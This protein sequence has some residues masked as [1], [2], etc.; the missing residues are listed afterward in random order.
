[1]IRALLNFCFGKKTN[2]KNR[3]RCDARK[4]S[5]RNEH[6]GTMLEA[7]L[8]IALIIL[9]IPFA[10]KQSFN[11]TAEINDI[12]LANNTRNL[13]DAMHSFLETYY[14]PIVDRNSDVD[15]I[16]FST[17]S[18]TVYVTISPTDFIN[19]GFLAPTT[20]TNDGFENEYEFRVKRVPIPNTTPPLYRLE[21]LMYADD[22]GENVPTLRRNNILSTIGSSGG[23]VTA[24]NTINGLHGAWQIDPNAEFGMPL[25][26]A[27]NKTQ[28]ISAYIRYQPPL[29]EVAQ[30]SD[31]HQPLYRNATGPVG[32]NIMATDLNMGGNDII[33]INS[34][35]GA[36]LNVSGDMNIT[37][38][39]VL[40]DVDASGGTI[41]SNDIEVS[42]NTHV[43]GTTTADNGITISAGG[44]DIT[45]KVSAGT[46]NIDINNI[47][48]SGS[49][50]TVD[51]KITALGNME[52]HE[53][54]ADIF[55]DKDAKWAHDAADPNAMQAYYRYYYGIADGDAIYA[56]E[57]AFYDQFYQA[58]PSGT[59]LMNDINLASRGGAALSD[60]LPNYIER[61]QYFLTN[62]TK[63]GTG[64][65][66][67][68]PVQ[69][70]D[71]PASINPLP[72]TTYEDRYEA[73]VDCMT[74]PRLTLTTIAEA[75]DQF[76]P[77][78]KCPYNYHRFMAIRP[79]KW[80]G[81]EI[82]M[83]DFGGKKIFQDQE[84]GWL[85]ITAE[86][87]EES[88]VHN[89]ITYT[90]LKGW[91]VLM[92]YIRR[93][94]L[95]DA[96]FSWN[97]YK[98]P[99]RTMEVEVMT[100]CMYGAGPS[101][102]GPGVD[103]SNAAIAIAAPYKSYEESED[104]VFGVTY[105]APVDVI[106]V[107]NPYISFRIDRTSNGTD[108]G[109]QMSVVNAEY[110]TGSGSDTLYF[111]YTVQ[112]G[113]MDVDGL[114]FA[115]TSINLNG[116]LI[117]MGGNNTEVDFSRIAPKMTNALI[118][119]IRIP[120]YT[121]PGGFVVPEFVAMMHEAKKGVNTVITPISSASDD[122]WTSIKW[123]DAKNACT[124]LDAILPGTYYLIADS[125]W[126]SIANQAFN[127]AYNW[128]GGVIGS[129]C[130]FSGNTGDVSVCEYDGLDPDTGTLSTRIGSDAFAER[131]RLE[132]T[133][134]SNIWD[135]GGN[136]GE[137][138]Y[139]D[140]NA[141]SCKQGG[142]ITLS[143]YTGSATN[144]WMG[145]DNAT[146]TNSALLPDGTS[147]TYDSSFHVGRIENSTTANQY[148]LRGGTSSDL[149]NAGAFALQ[150]KTGTYSATSTGFRCAQFNDNL[151]DTG[152]GCTIIEGLEQRANTVTTGY[153]IEQQIAVLENKSYVIVWKSADGDGYGIFGQMYNAENERQGT[154]FR[155]N[156]TTTDVQE[157]PYVAAIKDGGESGFVVTWTSSGQDGDGKGVYA[158]IY[159]AYGNKVG[160]EFPVNTYKTSDQ[161][162]PNVTG[163]TSGEFVITWDSDG[164]D[165][166]YFGVY[167]Q[168]FD[169]SGN[170]LGNEFRVNTQTTSHQRWS[171]ITY[172]TGGGFVVSYTGEDGDSTGIIAQQYDASANPVGTEFR[173]NAYIPYAQGTPSV[174]ALTDG[175][176]VITWTDVN[177][178]D[179]HEW[180]IFAQRYSASGTQIGTEIPVNTYTNNN[181]QYSHTAGLT[182]GGFVI[183]WQS[184]GQDGDS[185]GAFGQR[186]DKR[187]LKVDEEF[188]L[189]TYTTQAQRNVRVAPLA[190]G[191]F[192]S[193]WRSYI[194]DGSGDGVYFK[195]FPCVGGVS[196]PLPACV[197]IGEDE[198]FQV[199]TFEPDDQEE[200]S[201]ATLKNGKTVFVWESNGQDG[202]QQ[203]IYGQIIN[204]NG[205]KFGNEFPVN[206]Y[207]TSSQSNPSV[208]ALANGGFVIAWESF[209]QDGDYD[210]IYAQRYDASGN[211]VD[212][213]FKVNTETVNSQGAPAATALAN[214]DFVITWTSNNQDGNADGAYGQM[215]DA[216]GNPVDGE[217]LIN[218]IVTVNDQRNT[219]VAPL[220]E[221][222]FVITWNSA[223]QDG[224]GWGIHAKLYDK[225]GSEAGS[226]FTVNTTTANSQQYPSATGIANGGFVIT[227]ESEA[228][229]GDGY[230]IYAQIF[231]ET[232][233]AVGSEFRVNTQTA[234][235]QNYP[236]VYGINGGNFIITWQSDGQD[237]DGNG[238]YA[239]RFAEDGTTVGSEFQVA[240]R[241]TFDQTKPV[242]A[243]RTD[244][245]YVIAWQS[246]GQDDNGQGIFARM[247]PCVGSTSKGCEHIYEQEE[248]LVS[249][250]ITL[251]KYYPK[252]ATLTS[253][254]T[255]VAWTSNGQDGDSNGVYAQRY[256][257]QGS[258]IGGETRLNTTTAESQYLADIAPLT[259]GGYVVL[260]TH[261][262]FSS[263]ETWAQRFNADGSLYGA[264][265]LLKKPTTDGAMASSIT[266]LSNGGFIATWTIRG[267]VDGDGDGFGI[268]GQVYDN[269]SS[270]VGAEFQANT[271][272][273]GNQEDSDIAAFADD[274]FVVVWTSTGQ[275][276][277]NDG[278]YGQL[279]NADGTKNGEE[280]QV[281]TYTTDKQEQ[282]EVTVLE[283]GNFIV[284][285]ASYNQI[286]EHDIYGQLYN[287]NGVRIGAEFL[288]N[289]TLTAYNQN[290]PSVTA[291]RGGG[292]VVIWA[293][294][295]VDSDNYGIRAKRYDENGIAIDD[296]FGVNSVI[297][298]YQ[299]LPFVAALNDSGF[300]TAWTSGNDPS[301]GQEIR[302]KRYP[303]GDETGAG[304]ACKTLNG[305]T[306]VQVNAYTTNAQESPK[307]TRLNNGNIVVVWQ[308]IGQDVPAETDKYG[309]YG[310]IITPEGTKVGDVFQINTYTTNDQVN[311][312]ITALQN[313]KFMVGWRSNQQAGCTNFC[314]FGQVFNENGT[315]Y[316]PEFP[317]ST[318]TTGNHSSQKMATLTNGN[319]AVT[320]GGPGIGYDTYVKILDQFGNTVKDRFIANTMKSN[321]EFANDITALPDGGFVISWEDTG[322]PSFDGS[323]KGVAGQRFDENGN[324]MDGQFTLNTYVTS[325]QRA[326][327]L[328]TLKNGNFVATWPSFGQDGDDEG[329]YSQVYAPDGSTIGTEIHVSS[330]ITADNQTTPRITA[331]SGGGFLVTWT[332]QTFD[333]D[334]DLAIAAQQFDADGNKTGDEFLINEVT[335]GEQTRPDLLGLDD[336]GFMAIY[337]SPDGSNSGIFARPFKCG[338]FDYDRDDEFESVCASNNGSDE[339]RVNTYRTGEQSNSI[340]VSN[341]VDGNVIVAWQSEDQDGDGWGVYGQRYDTSGN[342]I[343]G[344]YLISHT[345]SND[346]II[347]TASALLQGSAY[348]SGRSIIGWSSNLEDGDGYG[349]YISGI[350]DIGTLGSPINT[351]VNDTTTGNQVFTN[352][353]I[354]RINGEGLGYVATWE[355]D[356]G[357]DGDGKG[358]YVRHY[359]EASA[360]NSETLVNTT[361]AGDQHSPVIAS[362][363]EGGYVV[364]WVSEGQDGDAGGIY[365]RIYDQDNFALT[366]EVQINTTN[367]VA[368]QS[369]PDIIGLPIS[370]MAVIVWEDEEGTPAG[371]RSIYGQ[372]IDREGNLVGGNFL[373]NTH[374]IG[375]QHAPSVAA[376]SDD[377]FIVAWVSD[378]QD[379]DGEGV[380]AQVFDKYGQPIGSEFQVNDIMEGNQ[381]EPYVARLETIAGFVITW[382][383]DMGTPYG[384][385]VHAKF[386]SC[387]GGDDTPPSG[388]CQNLF[389]S[390]EERVNTYTT[391]HQAIA[392]TTTLNSGK[393]VITWSSVGQDGSEGGIYAQLYDV[394]GNTIGNEFQVNT[395]TTS[396]QL[397]PSIAA[398]AD[399]GF[400]ITWHSNGQDGNGLGIYAQMYDVNGNTIGN[401]FQ[402]NTYT[403][404]NQ[405]L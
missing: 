267:G 25:T 78:P 37:T 351:R 316:N 286:H 107:S 273:T 77:A 58:N 356:G 335:A 137:W 67:T 302:M 155:I 314:I 360:Q 142:R 308:S 400:V 355:S 341:L 198:E 218:N 342:E 42:G 128:N 336:N 55:Y 50:S 112:P 339:I 116:A 101:F 195:P 397:Y 183:V 11:R 350:S 75:D 105:G 206:S 136:V 256:D 23:V 283:D 89:A 364:A 220:T 145:Y 224:D 193:V 340:A 158:Q 225:Y 271:F 260:W 208:A 387:N 34:I 202:D 74:S 160:T 138:I 223:L 215:Y 103:I 177:G 232:A 32:S 374:R 119:W 94:P 291:S 14:K 113:D 129:N 5:N 361:T 358:V 270:P 309:V 164:Q 19:N 175:G 307:A 330:G 24:D 173:V 201:I 349:S 140:G 312:S 108:P 294:D 288:I 345:A 398:L 109:E 38:V 87:I 306:E 191:G 346:Q 334:G 168:R 6:G 124:Q 68:K 114:E 235:S 310:Q 127:R 365:A 254:D 148:A 216:N 317:I 102:V 295:W 9:I 385:E 61:N 251:N 98:V 117:Q 252:I 322:T 372:I 96:G 404:S 357:Q 161:T 62:I 327:K 394:N 380:F 15:G 299:S 219:S 376:L 238:I 143:S 56:R 237:G 353:S 86:E 76:I 213:E 13:T 243:S 255:I 153:Q 120:E 181:Q 139:C 389:E 278:V 4:Q 384:K 326:A 12:A 352:R 222:G 52:A 381:N 275:D 99:Q 30:E 85:A 207:T 264:E 65:P 188:Q 132:I 149:S 227:W 66:G 156:T 189:N 371:S 332:S 399:G 250:D 403:S 199:N 45:G 262:S 212:S 141:G 221:G 80:M 301:Y 210:G 165:G 144:G 311:P 392:S 33:D 70:C 241:T 290:R 261:S 338:D 95:V 276:G 386:Y 313:G 239:Q 135:L 337:E 229:D 180:G 240:E 28:R 277:D 16:D 233:T 162:K 171:S 47:T 176:Y 324:K 36:T 226:E 64:W 395:Y 122:I 304:Q 328:A 281:N 287:N 390:P 300:I 169:T 10:L 192:I 40:G 246:D 79:R 48:S 1:M 344:E 170:P 325:D 18:D 211:T 331:L 172:L 402:V 3:T 366:G 289:S 51:A 20:R 123:A 236:H 49:I 84:N 71:D 249:N 378:V 151:I 253:G 377:S 315:K 134:I 26:D 97:H 106:G 150:S 269:T 279:F 203:G 35:T 159:D 131:A 323:G 369:N 228:Q 318:V 280:F 17:I 104:I 179:G 388:M 121:L 263:S 88:Y 375:N 333:G 200:V 362:L 92:G 196:D 194:Q 204:D 354:A 379:F 178:H 63:N 72:A 83:M 125:Q 373:V 57:T 303:C 182:D 274:S 285:W 230:G 391:D 234:G 347:P 90:Y 167:A 46:S 259:D 292:F 187:G 284:V 110:T 174:A 368:D 401:E 258:A 305:G 185:H 154:E 248:V 343:G 298:N 54:N 41:S 217:F 297:A 152:S 186:Y 163:L 73:T 321:D 147:G 29:A 21:A 53:I 7:T 257:R 359:I 82:N 367:Y 382:T 59:S 265:L 244:G 231:D 329:V 44:L 296:E 81:S 126:L 166:D 133:D 205:T 8:T 39:T 348:T 22:S 272:T 266:D 396:N 393:V 320:W 93:D 209:G 130:L 184:Y 242:V 214:G 43:I 197:N 383:S 363:G 293:G 100:Y 190:D 69:Y 245:G 370:G 60:I 27:A 31:A 111:K 282:P 115:S 91:N 157:L 319:V 247:Y 2:N 268:F 405:Y 118:E 146:I